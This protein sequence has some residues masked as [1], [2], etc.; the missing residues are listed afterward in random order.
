ME[1]EK[2]RVLIIKTGYAEVLHLEE[3]NH[4]RRVSFGDILRT[5]PILHIYKNG[6][7]TWVTDPKA[8][9]LLE[10]N[11]Y[12]DRLLPFDWIT[13]EQLKKER[14]DILINLEKTPG[15]CIVADS[16]YARKR[17]GF[18]FNPEKKRAEYYDN[19]AEILSLSSDLTLKKQNKK[20]A[21]ELLFEMLGKK[22]NGEEYILSYKPKSQEIYDI[23]LNVL[24]GKKWPTKAWPIENWDKLKEM[25]EKDGFK[26]TRQDEQG[27]DVL[28]NL[29]GYMDWINSSKL[30]VTP[31]TL[32]MHLAIALRK[33]VLAL[34]GPTPPQEAYFY[35]K[36]K[37]I[38][39]EPFDKC[40]P[41]FDNKCIRNKNCMD[42]ISV[43]RVYNE[44]KNMLVSE[45][46]LKSIKQERLNIR[47][48]CRACGNPDLELVFK[49]EPTP[50]GDRYV[51][52]EKI[53]DKQEV[54][55]LNLY[56]CKQCGLLQLLDILNPDI[57]YKEYIYN[58]SISLG[59]TEHFQKY[60]SY[61]LEKINPEK[62]SLV[63]D[64]GSNDGTLLKFFKNAGMRVLGIDPAVEVAKKAQE[65]GI[66]TIPDYFS[67]QLAKKIKQERGE[68]KIIT[69]NNTIA[70]IDDLDSVLQGVKELLSQDGV[71]VFETAYMPDLI[72]KNILDNIYHEHLSYFPTK[73]LK[74][75][76]S[77]N[78]ME[79]IH[80]EK[81]DT[82]G[83]SVRGFA[84]LIGSSGIISDS[85][86]RLIDEETNMGVYDSNFYKKFDDRI[87]FMKTKLISLLQDLKAQG[88]KIVGYG[89]SVG[90]TTMLYH[91]NLQKY[92]DFLVD[93]NPIRKDLFSPG[94]HIPVLQSD[95]IYET[96]PDYILTLAWRYS[97]P[98]IKKNL[99]YLKRGGKFIVID[100]Q[101]LDLKVIGK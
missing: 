27:E 21:Q 75:L 66:E 31:D 25:L 4:E 97:E 94:F 89:A 52:I 63:I 49:L 61:L 37:N 77:R 3:H 84:Q 96:K 9:P 33:K 20:T 68:A 71:F 51:I 65:N 87:N 90:V 53:N 36:G 93:D 50:P 17:F 54:Y 85:V 22:W 26:V 72:Q 7:V 12:I 62:D 73:A 8:F 46:E 88:K 99:E 59:L 80:I 10:G 57:L 44:I 16:I 78:G 19:A 43:E 83:G 82:K 6:E 55:P 35:G 101:N 14:F 11:Q 47:K 91:L 58:T 64:I 18:T 98:I 40:I 69:S 2:K 67:T 13:A 1:E 79:L 48:T 5:T 23:G 76:F 95:I 38:S 45:K 60:S 81:K 41:C 39:P 70:N 24:V 92:L 30:I 29:Y 15:I 74:I 42:D 100:M 32:G 56:F 28:E 86:Q 34:F